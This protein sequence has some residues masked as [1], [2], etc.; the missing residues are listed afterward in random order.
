MPDP[1][2]GRCLCGAVTFEFEPPALWSVGCHCESCRRQTGS[3]MTVFVGVRPDSWRW[4]GAEPKINRSSPQVERCF[5]GACGSPLSFRSMAMT[6]HMHFHATALE[7]PEAFP[8]T[9][10]VAIEEKLSWAHVPAEMET[11]SG[12]EVVAGAAGSRGE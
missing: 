2:K 9:R 3:P 1:V 12:P 6:G 8:P 4:T 7:D 11:K 10:H 5:C